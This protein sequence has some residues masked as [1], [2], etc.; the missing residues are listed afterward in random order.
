[1]T[2]PGSTVVSGGMV[3]GAV[4]PGYTV[5]LPT[6]AASHKCPDCGVDLAWSDYREGPYATGWTCNNGSICG[7]QMPPDGWFR[8]FCVRCSNDFCAKCKGPPGFSYAAAT[9]SAPTALVQNDFCTPALPA[10]SHG[11]AAQSSMS[12]AAIS[13][14]V[15]HG[16]AVQNRVMSAAEYEEY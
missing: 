7:S 3:S 2:T 15:S 14:A 8:W 5:G 10:V 11:A 1:M 12:R 13:P 6:A 4:T 16:A 9:T